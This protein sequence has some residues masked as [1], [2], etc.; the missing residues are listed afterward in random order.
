M[1]YLCLR[2]VIC[3]RFTVLDDFDREII[4][5]IEV[6]RR[7]RDGLAMDIKQGQILQD[8]LLEFRLPRT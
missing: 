6:I 7:V 5:L 1:A 8:R 4:Q 2:G 3:I